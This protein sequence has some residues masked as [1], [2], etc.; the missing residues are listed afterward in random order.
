MTIAFRMVLG[1]FSVNVEDA[2]FPPLKHEE[3]LGEGAGSELHA[4]P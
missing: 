4:I 1:W 2:L 3:G